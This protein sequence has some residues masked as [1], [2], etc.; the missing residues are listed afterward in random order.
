ELNELIEQHHA[1]TD[2]TFCIG[3]FN[4]VEIPVK[5][6][7]G[8]A[9]GWY[10]SGTAQFTTTRNLLGVKDSYREQNPHR[11]DFSHYSKQ[12]K[13]QSRIDRIYVNSI[14]I[15]CLLQS[16][17][18]TVGFSDHKIVSCYFTIDPLHEPRG[19]SY[20]KLNTSILNSDQIRE[21]IW[22]LVVHSALQEKRGEAFLEGWE[23]LKSDFKRVLVAFS[24]QRA[25]KRRVQN[26]NLEKSLAKVKEKLQEKPDNE[27]LLQQLDELYGQLKRNEI[28]KVK[29]IL[30]HSNY[31]NICFDRCNLFTAKK[32]QKRSAESKHLYALKRKNGE[33]VYKTREIVKEVRVQMEELFSKEETF[34]ENAEEFLSADLPRL[35]EEDRQT[36]EE[37][38]GYNEIAEAI[39]NMPKGKTPGGM[40]SPLNF[41][42]VLPIC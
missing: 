21:D 27:G 22:A 13:T 16:E 42:S 12:Y 19:P 3:D 33:T 9:E 14:L 18:Q 1:N 41:I 26:K 4:F 40:A 32:L 6:H 34:A 36:L 11:A 15:D 24:R 17:F 25:G 20:W 7:S 39:G 30:L 35:S 29:G 37:E 5:D 10:E 28:E 23:K 8:A 31:R 38:I 2:V